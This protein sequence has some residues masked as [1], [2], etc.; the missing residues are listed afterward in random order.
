MNHRFTCR[1]YYENT[2]LSGI[3]YYANHLKFIERARTE[4]VREPGIDQPALRADRGI[5]FAVRKVGAEYPLPAR[6]VPG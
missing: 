5:V 4:Y 3:V 1:V 2:D 6:S